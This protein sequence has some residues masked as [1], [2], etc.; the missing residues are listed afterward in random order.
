MQVN[1][2][3]LAKGISTWFTFLY[4]ESFPLNRKKKIEWMP[5]D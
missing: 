2:S 5:Y 1:N 3:E 4:Q